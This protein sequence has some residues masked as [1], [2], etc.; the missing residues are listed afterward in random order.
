[1][2][3][4][5]ATYFLLQNLL[6]IAPAPGTESAQNCSASPGQFAMNFVTFLFSES[7]LHR[8]C[9]RAKNRYIECSSFSESSL[10]R[11]CVKAKHRYMECCGCLA[12]FGATECILARGLE[13][14]NELARL[15]RMPHI[16][17]CSVAHACAID[18]PHC[19]H[20]AHA[21]RM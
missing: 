7:L 20:T 19:C 11:K 21:E 10:Q 9:I 18:P 17:S 12:T 6:R 8:A 15:I 14:L 2:C 3:Y 5:C 1:M 16:Y 4:L 13:Q